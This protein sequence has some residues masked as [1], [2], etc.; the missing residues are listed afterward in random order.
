MRINQVVETE[1]GAVTFQGNLTGPELA[2]VLEVGINVLV[3]R[4]AIPFASTKSTNIE[5][6]H[7]EGV[8]TVQ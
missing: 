3:Q 8:D 6:I 1:D 7:M 2:F 5:D 4:G